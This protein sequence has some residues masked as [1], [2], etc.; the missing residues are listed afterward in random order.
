ME[1]RRFII[2]FWVLLLVPA[3]V[4]SVVS[5]KLLLHEQERINRA[6]VTSFT[7]RAKIIARNIHITI[8]DVEENL[9]QSL[10]GIDK[11]Q[12][13][14]TLLLWEET[15]S[16]VRNVFIWDEKKLLLYPAKGVASTLEERSFIVRFD[17]FFSGEKAFIADMHTAAKEHDSLFDLAKGKVLKKTSFTPQY[18]WIPW[19][20]QNQL[21]ILGWVKKHQGGPV[22]G[23]ELELMSLLSRMVVN[24]PRPGKKGLSYA[25]LD[26]KQQVVHLSGDVL[27]K[28]AKDFD[29]SIA[30][31]DL[32]PHW[33]ICVYPDAESY[34]S[35]KGFLYLSLLLLFIFMAALICGGLLLT[36]QT[37]KHM[38]DAMEKAS[39][40]SSVS[41]ELK[42]PLTSIRLY[43]ELMLSGRN[44]SELKTKQ[45][46]EVMV[47]QSQ[48]LTRLINN[49]LDFGKL[50]Q[51]KKIYNRQKIDMDKLL[52]GIMNAHSI[53]IKKAGF[54]IVI[55]IDKADNNKDTFKVMSD[56]DALEQV[57]LNLLDNALKYAKD[58]RFL[59]LKLGVDHGFIL[60]KIHDHGP[61][62]SKKH[63]K[64]IFEKFYRIDNSLTSS[65]PGSGLGLTIARQILQDL[66]G[67]LILETK[68]TNGSS[69]I[70]RIPKYESN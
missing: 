22:Y 12:L 14:S 40:V 31:S 37:R 58:G 1:S 13:E 41:H 30:L 52:M 67:D 47:A 7:E 11:G 53:R 39:F 35:G 63:Q 2:I 43:A 25:V 18:G 59:G 42:T 6:A 27:V 45:Y 23:I 48:R 66:D 69:F 49:I 17:S 10:I 33:Q 68:E 51:G 56:P 32:L 24:L 50:E 46:L 64:A 62:I 65:F 16:L 61:G 20:S 28:D 34:A 57:I 3:V 36:W 70:V 44:Q 8:R 29:I 54:D 5:F 4:I 38:K 19:F 21:Y 55:D 60:L 15:N 9:S 26:S